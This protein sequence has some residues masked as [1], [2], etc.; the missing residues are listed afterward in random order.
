M[1]RRRGA[2]REEVIVADRLRRAI[3]NNLGPADYKPGPGNPPTPA[4]CS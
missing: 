2:P 4:A 3:D 1:G